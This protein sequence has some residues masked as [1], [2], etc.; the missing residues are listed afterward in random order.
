MQELDAES[1]RM[2]ELKREND[3]L[4]REAELLVL[5]KASLESTLVCC[6]EYS[7]ADAQT[8]AT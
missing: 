4:K 1:D 6:F 7:L 8:R 2:N 5:E 3:R